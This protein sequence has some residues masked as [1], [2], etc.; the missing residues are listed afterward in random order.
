MKYW[1]YDICFCLFEKD[2]EGIL[3]SAVVTLIVAP[4]NFTVR[5]VDTEKSFKLW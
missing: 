3:D 4:I 5:L 1:S 2:V